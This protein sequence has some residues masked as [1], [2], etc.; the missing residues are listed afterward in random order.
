MRQP[1]FHKLRK[2]VL[3]GQKNGHNGF[4]F[5]MGNVWQEDSPMPDRPLIVHCSGLGGR[6]QSP[7][8]EYDI[9]LSESRATESVWPLACHDR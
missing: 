9:F 4:F 2:L 6:L 3:T 8:H 7:D 5:S 1:I